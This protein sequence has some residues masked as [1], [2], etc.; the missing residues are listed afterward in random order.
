MVRPAITDLRVFQWGKETVNAFNT[1]T[2]DTLPTANDTI[3]IDGEVYTV[4]ASG[5]VAGQINVGANLAAF[6][7]NFVAA[8][9]GT[10]SINVPH[11]SV[12][13]GAFVANVSRISARLS[14]TAGNSIATT[15]TFTAVTNI[16]SG[17]VLSGGLDA[18]V[19]VPATSRMLVA[20]LDL[21]PTDQV[22]HPPL[23]RGLIQRYKGLEI[24][25]ERGTNF[26][27]PDSTAFFEQIPNWLSMSVR[28]GVLP[29]GSGPY[30]YDFVRD[31]TQHPDL[32]T[33]TLERR[34]SDGVNHIDREAAYAFLRNIVFRGAQNQPVMFSAQGSARRIQ[35]STLT[36]SITAPTAE[37][38][39]SSSSALYID[40]TWGGLGGTQILGQI[41]NWE[42]SWQTGYAP[43]FTIDGRSD[44]DFTVPAISSENTQLMLRVTMLVNPDTGQFATEQAAAE[45]QTLRAVRVQVNGTSSRRVRF[46][47]LVKHNLGSLFK[48]GEFEGQ[49]VVEMELVETTDGSN[50]FRVEVVNNVAAM[51]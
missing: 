23:L 29:T 32:D 30:T 10:D 42:I 36:A 39:L 37:A 44:L 17:A 31:P 13:A 16:F 24:V 4:V 41:L 22:Y 6:Q 35:S 9:N 51:V 3:T 28:G 43:L 27:I 48:V 47:M 2:V 5:A 20:D 33:W 11:P 38:M 7:T 19:A 14:G 15:E 45:A 8:I 25:I 21:E 50:L 18:G 12:R 40:T 46:D 26:N 34:L 1:L 49:D